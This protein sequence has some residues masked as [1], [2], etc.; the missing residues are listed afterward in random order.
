MADLSWDSLKYDPAL[1]KQIMEAANPYTGA[2]EYSAEMNYET[3]RPW[4]DAFT[5]DGMPADV[6]AKDRDKG[7]YTVSRENRN[8]GNRYEK[9]N[10]Q[11][12]PDGTATRLGDWAGYNKT[13]KE[14]MFLKGALAIGGIGLMGNAGLL[15][16]AIGGGGS[17]A[18]TAGGFAGVGEG[19]NGGLSAAQAAA[20]KSP[21]GAS[22]SRNATA[23][24]SGRSGLT[25]R[26][27]ASAGKASRNTS[28]KARALRCRAICPRGNT[29]ARR[30]S[31]CG[32]IR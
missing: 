17:A 4:G 5:F 15:G 26:S 10:Y 1:L 9:A 12:N 6:M 31:P 7:V 8:G 23:R 2:G 20:I 32:P 18:S 19:I 16:E 30:T 29:R 3:G 11:A 13:N 28:P 22:R 25:A 24:R 21:A 27:G 14:S